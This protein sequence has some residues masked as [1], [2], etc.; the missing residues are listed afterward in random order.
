VIA[1]DPIANEQRL[2]ELPRRC[3]D[4]QAT[5]IL[6]SDHEPGSGAA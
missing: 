3:G 6:S 2:L 5:W 4:V 1:D